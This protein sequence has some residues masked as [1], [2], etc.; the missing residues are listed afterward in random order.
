[1][2][3]RILADLRSAGRTGKSAGARAAET[4]GSAGERAAGSLG[5]AAEALHLE[6]V[7]TQLTG[8][9]SLTGHVM[10]M[11]LL[12]PAEGVHGPRETAALLYLF[13]DALA[14]RPTDDAPM[15]AV[16]L[17]GLHM[18]M[19]EVAIARWLYKAGRTTHANMDLDRREQEFAAALDRWTVDDFREATAKLQV[20]T[21]ADI[22]GQL[23]LYEHLGYVRMALPVAGGEAVRLKSALPEPAAAYVR[24][25][26]LFDA[27]SWPHGLTMEVPVGEHR[28][29]PAGDDRRAAE[30]DPPPA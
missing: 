5:S 17:F 24:M 13:R 18:V 9:R 22:P 23:H 28:E 16:P 3:H 4:V 25:W 2:S 1:M 19:P 30:R 11:R 20:H 27:V 26:E 8:E 12:I 14:I 29:E 21:S 15:S 7:R 10:G 6:V